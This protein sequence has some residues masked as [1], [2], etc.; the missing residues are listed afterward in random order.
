MNVMSSSGQ[1]HRLFAGSTDDV[2]ARAKGRMAGVAYPLEVIQNIADPA[3]GRAAVSDRCPVA[4]DLEGAT[5]TGLYSFAQERVSLQSAQC[6]SQGARHRC[7]RIR[8]SAGRLR[9]QGGMRPERSQERID[10]CSP[11]VKERLR[12]SHATVRVRY[13]RGQVWRRVEMSA[14]ETQ[15]PVRVGHHQPSFIHIRPLQARRAVRTANPGGRIITEAELV[16]VHRLDERRIERGVVSGH[17][18]RPLIRCRKLRRLCLSLLRV[19][20]RFLRRLGGGLLLAFKC[21]RDTKG[22]G[23]ADISRART[24]FVEKAL[25]CRVL[26]R[27]S[28]DRAQHL[29]HPLRTV[30]FL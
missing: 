7:G 3:R 30:F 10:R 9:C 6:R 14:L 2:P 12:P 1:R 23:Y 25:G 26:R 18:V 5:W 15:Q 16:L 29:R 24:D 21:R 20:L 19:K 11:V 17:R 27:L 13:G 28:L 22:G 4:R 8:R